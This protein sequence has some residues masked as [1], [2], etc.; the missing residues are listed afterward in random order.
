MGD[1]IPADRA[2]R[3]SAG[4]H[5]HGYRAVAQTVPTAYFCGN[6]FQDRRDAAA[7]NDEP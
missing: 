7:R 2:Q 5:N 4:I 6:G 1:V 3:V